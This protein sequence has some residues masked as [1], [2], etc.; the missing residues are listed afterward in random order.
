MDSTVR[1]LVKHTATSTVVE[2]TV[3]VLLEAIAAQ[4]GR[5]LNLSR[6]PSLL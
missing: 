3:E 1:E 6:L 2:H 5:V 4:L